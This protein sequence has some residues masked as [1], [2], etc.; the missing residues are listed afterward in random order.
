LAAFAED[1]APAAT[2][3][4]LWEEL[5]RLADWLGLERIEV[6]SRGDLARELAAVG[7]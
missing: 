1:H 5:R 4:A 7:K 3:A 2:A 6:F